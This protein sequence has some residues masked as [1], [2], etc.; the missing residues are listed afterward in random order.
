MSDATGFGSGGT[1][2][3]TQVGPS[4]S[5]KSCNTTDPGVDFSFNLD[6]AL[7]QCRQVL[8]SYV[9]FIPIWLIP[10][11]TYPFGGYNQ[12]VQPVTITVSSQFLA[13]GVL[14][15]EHTHVTGI[16]SRRVLIPV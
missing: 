1:S 10:S 6:S 14:V 9:D 5:G 12:A 15:V 16:Y 11:R 2:V 4:V 13:C 8:H 3:V 7:T